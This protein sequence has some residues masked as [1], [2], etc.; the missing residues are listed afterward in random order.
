M[1]GRNKDAM[2]GF[3]SFVIPLAGIILGIIYFVRPVYMH[4]RTS[5]ICF[6]WG[7]VCLLSIYLFQILKT[8]SERF[9]M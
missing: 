2:L 1:R 3:V 5:C 8:V 4:R 6:V 9:Y 7:V